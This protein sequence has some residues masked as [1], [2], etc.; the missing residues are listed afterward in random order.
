MMTMIEQQVAESCQIHRPIGQP[1]GLHGHLP[2][3]PVSLVIDW[4]SSSGVGRGKSLRR[5]FWR[6]TNSMA[7]LNDG[8]KTTTTT[9]T[10]PNK[11]LRD[12]PPNL[13]SLLHWC[14]TVVVKAAR[15]HWVQPWAMGLTFPLRVAAALEKLDDSGRLTTASR[16][17]NSHLGLIGHALRVCV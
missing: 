9:T 1:A 12:L 3:S 2:G 13:A 16:G 17:S 6:P 15:T 5:D 11:S 10:F 4:A 14:L 8:Q 7:T